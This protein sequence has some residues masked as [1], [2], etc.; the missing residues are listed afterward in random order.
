MM[1][2]K[3]SLTVFSLTMLNIASILSIRNWPFMVE[4][5]FSSICYILLAALMFFIP[6]SLVSAELATAMPER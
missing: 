4:Y 2:T 3:R 5:G 6:V 1:A